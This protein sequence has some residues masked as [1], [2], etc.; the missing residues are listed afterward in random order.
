M[1]SKLFLKISFFFAVSTALFN[2]VAA[3]CT[4]M[5][6]WL[7]GAGEGFL[8]I[9]VA[10]YDTQDP[11]STD[12]PT[13]VCN[14]TIFT[15]NGNSASS[16]ECTTPTVESA[17]WTLQAGILDVSKMTSGGHT[18]YVVSSTPTSAGGTGKVMTMEAK[19]AL[20]ETLIPLSSGKPTITQSLFTYETGCSS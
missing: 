3:D 19:F 8:N 13:S 20:T 11:T 7:R 14:N 6:L 5:N 1:L 2:L 17:P 10:V 15:F 16:L 18:D 9:G 4:R 12:V